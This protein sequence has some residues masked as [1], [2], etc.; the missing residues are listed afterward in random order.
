MKKI[1]AILLLFL[2]MSTLVK[3][4]NV[5]DALRYSQLF[6]GGTARFL[7][8]GGAFTA[9]GGDISSL[10]QN[11]AGLGVFRSSEFT[12]TPQ[13]YHI[14]TT[15]ELFANQSMDYLYNFN[16]GQAGIVANLINN[17][18]ESGLITLNLGYSFNRSNSFK[19]SLISEGTSDN[20]S[21]LDLWSDM[22]YGW[23]RDELEA[24][25]AE[26]FLGWGTYLIDSLP[27]SNTEYGTV[28]SN[29]GDNSGSYGQFMRRIITT[30]GFS[31]E[32]AISI[33]GNYSNKLFLGATFGITRINYESK[34]E[35]LESVETPRYSGRYGTDGFTDFNYS[36]YYQNIATGYSLKLGVIYKPI[37]NLRLGFAFHS[38]TFYRI[39]EY[40]DDEISAYFEGNYLPNP[41]DYES[42]R[43]NY[44]LTTPFRIIGGAAFQLKKFALFSADYEFIDYS[45]AKFSET[46][47]EFDYTDKNHEIRN[48][49]RPVTNLRLGA[50]FRLSNLY[51]RGGY[52]FYGRPWASG[53]LNEDQLW[54]TISCGIGFRENNIFADLGFSRMTDSE[55]N[56]LY[57]SSVETVI[58]NNHI[59]KNMFTVTFG[60]KFGY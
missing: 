42:I 60:Y 9:L 33:G 51:L 16:L 53:E 15:S 47:D 49:L 13:L 43:F 30:D 48:S 14:K 7:S 50:E 44:A 4:Q 2:S 37:E 29:Y 25:V 32:H 1:S 58:A 40:I 21:L 5:D 41:P 24:N 55:H 23:N 3:S 26:A 27:G 35:H 12:I 6:Y 20:S 59:T 22:G 28:Y 8:M 39:D 57:D 36:F 46:G 45:T 34:Y 56:I 11:P 54:N 52:G 18:S 17:N 10:S 38:P 19:Q 31:G